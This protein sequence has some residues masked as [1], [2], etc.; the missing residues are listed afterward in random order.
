MTGRPRR[1]A[2]LLWATLAAVAVVLGVALGFAWSSGPAAWPPSSL[3]QLMAL[4]QAG[5]TAAPLFALADQH[6]ERVSLASLRGRVVVLESMDPKCTDICPIV[7]QEFVDAAKALGPRARDVVF[8]AVNV[9]QFHERTADVEAFSRVHGLD[10]LPNWHFLTGSTA[11][12][13]RVW[14]QYGIS[15]KPNPTGDVVHSA[16]MYFVDRRGRERWLAWPD[17]DK[18][19]IPAW[20]AGIAAVA[21]HLL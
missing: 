9:N 11:Q 12:L 21:E 8:L 2:R 20:G 7:S 14:K 17:H 16:L 13:E 1:A 19:Q 5:D 6:G 3:Q 18:A 4:T 15:V 10:A